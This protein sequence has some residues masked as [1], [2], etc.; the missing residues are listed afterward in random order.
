MIIDYYIDE[1][2]FLTYQLYTASRS[3]RLNKAR[4]QRI[5]IIPLLYIAF[6]LV[7]LWMDNVLTSCIF[8]TLGTLVFS[9]PYEEKKRYIK[10]YKGYIK[11]N[12]KDRLGKVTK[13]ELS[14]EF[15]LAKNDEME[16]KVSTTEIEEKE[17]QR[18]ILG[19]KLY[20]FMESID[21]KLPFNF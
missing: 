14:N 11:E 20:N 10:N 18:D 6:G 21:N 4:K 9:V 16:N 7:L 2:D 19:D 12:Y 1:N 15:I 17:L 3:N 5:V 13:L 8:F